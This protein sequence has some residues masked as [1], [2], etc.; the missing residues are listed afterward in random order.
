MTENF[1]EILNGLDKYVKKISEIKDIF[2]ANLVMLSEIPSPTFGE[3]QRRDFILDRFTEYELQNCSVDEKSN[4]LAVIPGKTGEK[5]ILLCAHM[6]TVFPV[7][8]DHT[9]AIQPDLVTGPGVADNGVGLAALVTLPLILKNL[10]L[11]FNS[12]IILIG[13]ARSLGKGDLEGL[14]F[15]LNHSKMTINNGICLE[16]VR[17]GRISYSSIGM[18]RGE[19]TYKI[20]EEYD[21]TRFNSVGAIVN[22]T[23]MIARILEIPLPRKPRTSINLGSVEGGSSYNMQAMKAKLKFEIRSESE[24]MVES[25]ATQISSLADEMASKTGSEVKFVEVARRKPGGTDFSHPLNTRA[26]EILNKLGIKP[27]FSPS[28][29]ELAA[30]IDKGIPALTMGITSGENISEIEESIH[31]QP[32]YTGLAQIVAMIQAIDGGFCNAN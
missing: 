11:T 26:R 7:K 22:M 32:L 17:L 9:V 13:T 15:F 3:E 10:D 4:A 19:L 25:L 27:R 18:L 5:N 2:L 20:P 16:G 24:E 12:N 30:F 6:D 14:R 1:D 23:E 8:V 21:W 31:I 28:T 29:S